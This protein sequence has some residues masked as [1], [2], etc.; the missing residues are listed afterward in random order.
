[1]GCQQAVG[2]ALALFFPSGQRYDYG[3]DKTHN[4]KPEPMNMNNGTTRKVH[5]LV[6]D[7]AWERFPCPSMAVLTA[8]QTTPQPPRFQNG[9]W[10]DWNCSACSD[11]RP[12]IRPGA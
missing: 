2:Q 10:S 7:L 5:D 1:M 3:K 6:H 8:N 9:D 12:A 4:D 11:A